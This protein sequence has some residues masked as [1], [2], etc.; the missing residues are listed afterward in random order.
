MN[1]KKL[2]LIGAAF[3]GIAFANA[4][5]TNA[6]AEAAKKAASEET[7]KCYGANACK[8]QGSC[9]GKVDGCDGKNG[10]DTKTSCAGQNACKGKGIMKMSKEECAAKGGKVAV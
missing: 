9:H 3:A 10:C 1:N 6:P 4:D 5:K 8:G 2:L 7:V